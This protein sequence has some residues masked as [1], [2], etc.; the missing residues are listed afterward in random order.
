M[1]TE[2]NIGSL[3]NFGITT[4]G[5]SIVSRIG[6]NVARDFMES[7]RILNVNIGKRE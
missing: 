7:T 3:F 5:A 6:T 1:S 2:D 4:F